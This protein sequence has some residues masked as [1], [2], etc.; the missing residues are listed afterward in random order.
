[1]SKSLEEIE[2]IQSDVLSKVMEM[3]RDNIHAFSHNFLKVLNEE[4]GDKQL[5]LFEKHLT[6]LFEVL[7]QSASAVT[8]ETLNQTFNS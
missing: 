3:N 2:K 1:M 4:S 6:S 5:E 8:N 7:I